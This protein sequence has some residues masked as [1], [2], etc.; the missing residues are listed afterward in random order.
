MGHEKH[1]TGWQWMISPWLLGCGH[2]IL[3]ISVIFFFFLWYHILS[4]VQVDRQILSVLCH[5]NHWNLGYL[6]S[7]RNIHLP[8][9]GD[10]PRVRGFGR[11]QVANTQSQEDVVRH[12]EQL[13]SLTWIMFLP[14]CSCYQWVIMF[15]DWNTLWTKRKALG[16][17]LLLCAGSKALR[18]N[19]WCDSGSLWFSFLDVLISI[20]F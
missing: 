15:L 6:K 10:F 11:G 4:K 8:S 17:L 3:V 16:L 18:L 5:I 14:C 7:E 20:L 9:E 2:M 1:E 13:L 19:S 12:L